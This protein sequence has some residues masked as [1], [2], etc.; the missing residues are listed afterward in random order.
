[1]KA[2]SPR[3]FRERID[4]KIVILEKAENSQIDADA[5]DE[6]TLAFHRIGEPIQIQANVKIEDRRKAQQ[7]KEAVIP[8]A[9]EDVTG[10]NN[11][12]IAGAEMI[13]ND[14]VEEEKRRE[15]LEEKAGIE[16]HLKK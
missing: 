3:E 2:K 15:E 4:E 11:E 8:R 12:N 6:K 10:D 7:E 1:M 5:G 9:V 13:A 16:E 14:V